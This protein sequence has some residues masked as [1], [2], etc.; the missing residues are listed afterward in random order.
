MLHLQATGQVRGVVG[1][2][3]QWSEQDTPTPRSRLA[4][5]KALVDLRLMDRAWVALREVTDNPHFAVEGHRVTAEMFILRGWPKRARTALQAA[6]TEAPEDKHLN[7]LWERASRPPTPI[8]DTPP[9]GVDASLERAEARLSQGGFLRAQRLIEAVLREQPDNRR[10]ADLL[11]ALEGDFHLGG[12]LHE[13]CERLGPSVAE[14]AELSDDV[15]HTQSITAEEFEDDTGEDAHFPV[16]FREEGDPVTEEYDDGAEVTQTRLMASTSQMLEDPMEV[17]REMAGGDTQIL[18]VIEKSTGPELARADGQVHVG[19]HDAPEMDFDLDAYR[20]EMG[21]L[22]EKPSH[23]GSD[24]EPL[25]TE[26]NDVIVFTQREFTDSIQGLE[27][28]PSEDTMSHPDARRFL[29]EEARASADKEFMARARAMAELERRAMTEEITVKTAAP[30][31]EPRQKKRTQADFV[32]RNAGWIAAIVV[33]LLLA[34]FV[35]V[36]AIGVRLFSG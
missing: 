11:W 23:P 32:A 9:E 34:I 20:R 12:T 2:V 30:P 19:S 17:P 24:L 28:D 16:L 8:P 10:A 18:R 1:L 15:E 3:E 6:L 5:A 29:S 13:L 35:L 36:F 22:D 27:P 14:L 26:D 31:S 4:Q 25:E 33:A 21:V 7:D